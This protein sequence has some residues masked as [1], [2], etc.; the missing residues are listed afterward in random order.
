MTA[1][2]T[3]AYEPDTTYEVK[4]AKVTTF[5]R[6]TFRPRGTYPTVKGKVLNELPA[7]AIASATPVSA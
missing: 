3:P 7:D 6:T 2:K 5:R 1:K 4:F